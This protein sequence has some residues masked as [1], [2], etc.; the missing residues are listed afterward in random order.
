MKDLRKQS[1]LAF[2][3]IILFSLLSSCSNTKFLKEGDYLYTG[4]DIKIKTD[5]LPSSDKKEL[6]TALEEKVIPKPNS[7]FLGLRPRL[8]IYNIT[9]EPEKQKGFRYWLK[10]KVGEKPV[11]LKD[12]DR[13]FNKEIIQ[14]Y[15]ENKGYFNAKAKYDT[16]SSGRKAKVIYELNPKQR[17]YISKVTFPTDSTVL[18]DEIR[19]TERRSFL[20]VGE[21]FDL[22]VIKAERERIDTRLKQKGFYY[23]HSDNLL[24]QADSTVS[25]NQ[26]VELLLKIKYNTPEMAK[27]QFTI[28]KVVI[29]QIIIFKAHEIEEV[30]IKFL[31]I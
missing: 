8:Y 1:L 25:T 31:L 17:Y 29:F 7:S 20:K 23:F 2:A 13:E 12:V 24:V 16:A 4:A 11:L 27:N 6:K 9:K 15:A 26:K 21:P 22:D 3:G 18:G 19:K 30:F 14:N 5:S 10:Y 28:D